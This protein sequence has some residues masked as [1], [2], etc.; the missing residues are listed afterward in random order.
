MCHNFSFTINE[1]YTHKCI[2]FIML[3]SARAFVHVK[4]LVL[5]HRPLVRSDW[6]AVVLGFGGYFDLASLGLLDFQI[7]FFVFYLFLIL[8]GFRSGFVEVFLALWFGLLVAV[9]CFLSGWWQCF[10][11][12]VV[13]W[14]LASLPHVEFWVVGDGGLCNC[15]CIWWVKNYELYFFI[16]S[17]NKHWKIISIV[18]SS[19]QSNMV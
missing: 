10:E 15:A 8:F 17:W 3:L 1:W 5:S 16:L 4:R 19:W 13:F 18:F 14:W 7:W 11:W 9:G 2:N 6:R 12:L